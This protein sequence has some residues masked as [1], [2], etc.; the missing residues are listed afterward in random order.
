MVIVQS[1]VASSGLSSN[2][3]IQPKSFTKPFKAI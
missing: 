3:L 1:P 2:M